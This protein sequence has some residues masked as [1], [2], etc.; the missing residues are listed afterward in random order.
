MHVFFRCSSLA[1]DRIVCQPGTKHHM[2]G[3][4]GRMVMHMK[5]GRG[6]VTACQSSSPE[7]TGD[8][9][10]IEMARLGSLGMENR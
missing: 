4:R 1:E 10:M 3:M 6:A 7:E 2:A 9:G 5:G 8:K